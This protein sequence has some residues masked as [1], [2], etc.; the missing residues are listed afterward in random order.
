MNDL[1]ILGPAASRVNLPDLG[2]G[3][4]E[5]G[6]GLGPGLAQTLPFRPGAGAA[7]GG[8][9]TKSSVVINWINGSGG[10]TDLAPIGFQFF[11]HK[12]GESRIDSLAQFGMIDDDSDDIVR[13]NAEKGIW[14]KRKSQTFVRPER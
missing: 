8:L 13:I 5:H 12:H 2:G 7:A 6:F 11:R 4:E 3:G 10:N 14:C 9:H 1:A